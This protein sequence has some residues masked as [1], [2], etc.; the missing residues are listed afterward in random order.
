MTTEIEKQSL[1]NPNNA[2]G[3]DDRGKVFA[4]RVFYIAEKTEMSIKVASF[5]HLCE[6]CVEII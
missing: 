1:Q 6:I 2:Q 5:S 4:G 3:S